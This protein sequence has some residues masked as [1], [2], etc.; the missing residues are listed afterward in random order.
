MKDNQGA[1]LSGTQLTGT[2]AI[3][4]K[5][6]L[7]DLAI[8]KM[9]VNKKEKTLDKTVRFL[10]F[11]T[12]YLMRCPGLSGGQGEKKSSNT[13]AEKKLNP[14]SDNQNLK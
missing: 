7:Q 1:E 13:F 8:N 6:I 9:K 11:I 2:Q 5:K 3:C 12:R 4:R 10:M 14:D